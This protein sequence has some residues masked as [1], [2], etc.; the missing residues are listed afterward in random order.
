MDKLKLI[1][2]YSHTIYSDILASVMTK[3]CLLLFFLVKS[4]VYKLCIFELLKK[5]KFSVLKLQLQ[6]NQLFPFKFYFQN[7]VMKVCSTICNKSYIEKL[8][9]FV[10][11]FEKEGNCFS[12]NKTDHFAICIRQELVPKGRTHFY[13]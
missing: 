13:Y 5:W 12:S 7:L 9:F 11:L 10:I 2:F 4:I 3:S 6:T 1:S 8:Y